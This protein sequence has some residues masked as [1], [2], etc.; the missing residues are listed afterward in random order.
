MGI[1]SNQ[2]REAKAISSE[3]RSQLPLLGFGRDSKAG[4]GVGKL[5]GLKRGDQ[6][7]PEWRLSAWGA[8]SGLTG[9]GTSYVTA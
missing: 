4:R 3:Q 9:S 2:M 8:L 6:V 1:K 7:C 5:M